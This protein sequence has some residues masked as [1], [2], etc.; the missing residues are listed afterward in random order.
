MTQQTKIDR[1][2][3]EFLDAQSRGRS[4]ATGERYARVIAQLREFLDVVEVDAMLG[5]DPG[6][7]LRAEREFGASGAFA[8]V[9][10]PA[11]LAVCLRAFLAPEWRLEPR[12]LWV[13]QVSLVGRFVTWLR[14][15][16]WIDMRVWACAVWDVEAEVVRQRELIRAV[17]AQGGR[18]A[19]GAPGP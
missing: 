13:T 14:R 18:S 2:L 15:H 17:A 6:T 5:T 8:R 16:G 1:V 12:A 7:M 9:F 4:P 10:D 19:T 3:E 11:E